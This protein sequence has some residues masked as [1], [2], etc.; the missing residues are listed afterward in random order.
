MNRA[1]LWAS[2]FLGAALAGPLHATAT[3]V[4]VA[5]VGTAVPYVDPDGLDPQ[6]EAILDACFVD[7]NSMHFDRAEAEALQAMALQPD[8]PMPV[9]YLQAT[10]MNEVE[11]LRAAHAKDKDVADRFFLATKH[12]LALEAAWD[13]SHH[14]GRGLGYMGMSLG[15]RGMVQL[16]R[17]HP[18]AAYHDGRKAN[19]ELLLARRRDPSLIEADLG[20]GEYLYYCGRMAGVLRMILA[21]HG[22]VPGGIALLQ[23]CA[24]DGR[25][26]A[27]M[28]RLQLAQIF[29]EEVVNYE[30]ALPYDQEAEAR[31]PDNWYYE[32]LA[33]EDARGL[34]LDHPAARNLVEAVAA[35]WDAG[36]RPPVYAKLD[37]DPLRLKLAELYLHEGLEVDALRHLEAVEKDKGPAAARARRLEARLT[38]GLWSAAH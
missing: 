18:V 25:R 34:G 12:A 33:L 17:G 37:P 23:T 32:K 24:V 13:G 36:W 6:T 4:G 30:K 19:T 14:D 31:F 7:Y 11:E 21:L 16:F 38:P 8:L 27:P 3:D 5:P 29:T 1:C 10:L 9:I 20:L 15:E 28:A 22:D 26:C 35:H 2:C